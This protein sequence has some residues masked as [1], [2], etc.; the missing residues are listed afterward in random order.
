MLPGVNK[1][2]DDLLFLRQFNWVSF[3]SLEDDFAFDDLEW[4]ITGVKPVLNEKK[5]KSI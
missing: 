5:D 3:E 1:I 2:P 4:G